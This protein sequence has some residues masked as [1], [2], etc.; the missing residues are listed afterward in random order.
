MKDLF[1]YP[2]TWPANLRAVL[3]C[4]MAKE[5]TYTN[6]INL[7]IDLFKLGYSIEYGLECIPYNLRK[8]GTN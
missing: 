6:L 5:Q 8:I 3:A 4:Y 2:E 7:E 1:E